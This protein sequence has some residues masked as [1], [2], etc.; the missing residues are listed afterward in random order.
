MPTWSDF[1]S[2]FNWVSLVS[3]AF[4]LIAALLCIT[5]HELAH[6]FAAYRLGDHTA[7]NAGRLTLNPLRHLDVFGLLMMITVRVG[8]AKPVPIDMRNFHR[9]KRDM[10]ITALA[11]PAANLLI[12]VVALL[13][14]RLVYAFAPASEA[15]TYGI[16]ALL[17]VAV[18]S[19][20]LAAFNLIPISPLDGSKILLSFLPDKVCYQILSK[21]R[22][23][24][25]AMVALAWLGA[26][27]KPLDFLMGHGMELLCRLTGFPWEIVSYYFF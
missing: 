20:G 10:A 18:L 1:F 4:S 21:E 9:P 22:Y 15:S 8:W 5:L 23:I 11:G 14:A 16:L 12:S 27:E 25:I 24:A 17:Y 3:F 13:C 26:F 19:L 2:N 7:K 6:G